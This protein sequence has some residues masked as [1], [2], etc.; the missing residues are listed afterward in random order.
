MHNGVN[1]LGLGGI[2]ED[3]FEEV[4]FKL[5]CKGWAGVREEKWRRKIGVS[6]GQTTQ[7][8][9]GWEE[10]AFFKQWCAGKC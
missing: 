9:R 4:T 5:Q 1:T 6:G 7:R 8:P 3:F 2:K 10:P